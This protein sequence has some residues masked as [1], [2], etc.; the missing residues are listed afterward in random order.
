[1]KVR[2]A[3]YH[4]VHDYPGGVADLATRMG[5]APS[6][7]QNLA[8]PRIETHEWTLKRIRQLFD[9]TGDL[10]IA[11][12]FAAEF[13]GMFLPLAG[14]SDGGDSDVFRLATSLAKEFGDVVSEIQASMADGRVSQFER[15]RV[16]QQIYELNRAAHN[17]GLHIDQL[18]QGPTRPLSVVKK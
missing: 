13:G 9:F 14:G 15:E 8:N 17:V 12:A 6:T 11:H 2:D 16:H 7:L 3:L 4:A 18:A 1:M 5:L 10:R